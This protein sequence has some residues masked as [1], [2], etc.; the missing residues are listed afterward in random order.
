MTSFP[1]N[2]NRARAEAAPPLWRDLRILNAL[3]LAGIA[4]FFVG[5]LVLN[6]QAA[7]KGFAIRAMEKHIADL[8]DQGQRL[9]L[10]VVASQSMDAINDRI[11]TMGF[12][13]VSSL[14]YVDAAGG[15]VAVR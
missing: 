11:K 14:D 7:T 10:Q 2:R 8:T 3:L 9:D 1:H 15:A 5:Y 6:N 13:P 4:A 12:V